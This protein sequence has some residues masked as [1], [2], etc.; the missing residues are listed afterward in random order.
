[1]PDGTRP[2][3]L[4]GAFALGLFGMGLC[5]GVV[6]RA[7]AT[8]T[9]PSAALAE[10]KFC[11]ESA[12]PVALGS[13]QWNGW[14][15]DVENTRYQPEPALRATDV[16]KLALK[17]AF[18]YAGSAVSG[19]PTIVD[20]RVFVTSASGRVYR[21]LRLW[22]P[23]APIELSGAGRSAHRG[24]GRRAPAPP[25]YAAR[26]KKSKHQRTLAHLVLQMTPSAVFFGDERGAVYALD[27][28]KGTLL[29]K[30]Q[31]DA[32]PMARI[33]A[34]PTL[35]RD[36]LYVAVA[37]SEPSA[38]VDSTYASLHFSRQRGGARYRERP[39]P[40]E[41]L[42][43]ERGAAALSHQHNGRSS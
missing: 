26:P 42:H 6:E 19:Q 7:A 21:R 29:W 2:V 35:Y 4:P 13:A 14:G 38:A 25:K 27:A 28:E 34:A 10:K 40:M 20:E 18:G 11:A 23:A 17:W 3:A 39:C 32:H 22:K 33:Q 8:E 16:P 15:R 31:V 30:T 37:S 43:G 24:L 36:R 1:M 5:T 41:N 12:G 9:A